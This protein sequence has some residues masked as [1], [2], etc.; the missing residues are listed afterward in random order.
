MEK[1]FATKNHRELW[2]GIQKITNYNSKENQNS[3]QTTNNDVCNEL[4]QFYARFENNVN[5]NEIE[6]LKQNLSKP[7]HYVIEE[8]IV[9]ETLKKL[10]SRK[11]SGPDN[12]SPFILE[13]CAN[14]LSIIYKDLFEACITD[15]IPIIWKTSTII[16]V[17]KCSTTKE[18]NDFR[19]I[20]L[21][22]VPFKC[23]ERII[24]QKLSYI[25]EPKL[26]PQ[27]YAYRK[28]NGTEDAILTLINTIVNI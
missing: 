9:A 22:F 11:S 18:L 5:K 12:V 10:N 20:A 7:S 19:P 28:C 1:N 15:Y 4:N 25:C 26:D 8:R 23:L 27:Q 13:E 14:E 3:L 21:T 16:P 2:K 17:P 6:Q 24:L